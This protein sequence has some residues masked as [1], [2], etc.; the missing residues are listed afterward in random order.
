[1]IVYMEIVHNQP[2]LFKERFKFRSDA[3]AGC[4]PDIYRCRDVDKT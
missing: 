2:L 4:G 1:M 3:V